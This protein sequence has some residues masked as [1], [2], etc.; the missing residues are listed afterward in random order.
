M[1]PLSAEA[2]NLCMRSNPATLIEVSGSSSMAGI[3][4]VSNGKATIGNSDIFA[5]PDKSGTLED[6]HVG[7]VGIAVMANSGAFNARLAS[8][9][10]KQVR[11]IFA[12]R[13]R[14]WKEV[15]GRDQPMVVLQ[16]PTDSGTRT[17][18]ASVVMDGDT[19][20]SGAQEIGSSGKM[21]T[22]LRDTAGAISYLV[23]SHA[24]PELKIFALEE[25]APSSENIEDGKYPLWA[26]EHM[27]TKRPM[28]TA[29]QPLVDRILSEDFQQN[30]LPRLGFIPIARMRVSRGRD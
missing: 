10:R 4:D 27:Y 6:V 17:V 23:L 19:L 28:P 9:T 1:V 7:V 15:G 3:D 22:A 2:A 5:S 12:G 25:V 16:R 30:T 29:V 20:V 11:D 14:N 8:L 24:H 21:Q 18:F 13:I 26:Y